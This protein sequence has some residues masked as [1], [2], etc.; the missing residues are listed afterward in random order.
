M[1]VSGASSMRG[2]GR[3]P[4]WGMRGTQSV[5]VIRSRKKSFHSSRPHSL[6][7]QHNI[8]YNKHGSSHVNIISASQHY[9]Y[10]PLAADGNGGD[11]GGGPPGAGGVGVGTAGLGG[12]TT[13]SSSGARLGC[14]WILS[15]SRFA[16]SQ[17]SK[18]CD[19]GPKSAR[20]VYVVE[21]NRD[22][23]SYTTPCGS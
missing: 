3:T 21:R 17:A 14:A 19:V 2:G 12:T 9:R 15:I 10:I 1:S 13:G 22:E 18:F 11:F 8:L 5:W 4:W 20:V 7:K 16:S 23:P 6:Y